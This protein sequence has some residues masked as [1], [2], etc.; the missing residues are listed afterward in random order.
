ML[1]Y[2]SK[3]DIEEKISKQRDNKWTIRLLEKTKS[4]LNLW[5]HFINITV[6][7]AEMHVSLYPIHMFSLHRSLRKAT[8]LVKIP[9][10]E[11]IGLLGGTKCWTIF[12][13]A[14]NNYVI[15]EYKVLN[16]SSK[17]NIKEKMLKQRDNKWIIRLLEKTKPCPIF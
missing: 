10:H 14:R 11:I 6:F 12:P 17:S 1:N 5:A 8:S 13:K 16:Y 9:K 15:K 3:S 7:S 2:S 4:C